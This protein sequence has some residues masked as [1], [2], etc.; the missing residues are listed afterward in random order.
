MTK[1]EFILKYVEKS[2]HTITI[3]EAVDDIDVLFK[4]LRNI[5]ISQRKVSFFRK[6]TFELF[7]RKAR[8]IGNPASHTTMQLP[9]EKTIRFKPS[10]LLNKLFNNI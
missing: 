8:V 7:E 2:H 4:T 1:K 5:L 3:K 9:A 10:P 6:G